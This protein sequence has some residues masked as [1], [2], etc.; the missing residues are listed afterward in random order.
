MIAYN[1]FSHIGLKRKEINR[2]ERLCS[3]WQSFRCDLF[4]QE[5]LLPNRSMNLV[6]EIYLII[7]CS[8]NIEFNYHSSDRHIEKKM[9]TENQRNIDKFS[10]LHLS[11]IIIFFFS[12]LILM[13]HHRWSIK[14]EKE[15]V[16]RSINILTDQS[17]I[18][19][20]PM[21]NCNKKNLSIWIFQSV[22]LPLPGNIFFHTAKVM[23][24][25]SILSF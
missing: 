12:H 1:F 25:K 18:R 7:I 10:N 9:R 24:L 4:S 20:F 23:F 11:G 6:N 3:M 14:R 16:I 21:K 17:V 5:W 13:N 8:L 22:R 19:C 15:H 2:R